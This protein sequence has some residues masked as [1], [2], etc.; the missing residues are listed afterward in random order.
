MS[1]LIILFIPL[2]LPIILQYQVYD[3]DLPK[4]RGEKHAEVS[5]KTIIYIQSAKINGN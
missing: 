5:K 3:M 2:C 4:K 1:F